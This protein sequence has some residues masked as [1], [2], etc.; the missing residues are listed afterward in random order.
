ML[1]HGL[2]H[3]LFTITFFL[4]ME[5]WLFPGMSGFEGLLCLRRLPGSAF[6]F[7][8][9]SLIPKEEVSFN[10]GRVFVFLTYRDVSDSVNT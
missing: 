9:N 4:V 8:T 1:F 10:A 2:T 6:P 3:F 5:P 7:Y